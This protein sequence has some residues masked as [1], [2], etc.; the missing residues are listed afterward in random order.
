MRASCRVDMDLGL[1]EGADF[2]GRSLILGLFLLF[3]DAAEAVDG[4]YN[5]E[6]ADCRQ[7]EGEQRVDEI[8]E[9]KAGAD[10]VK[11][12]EAAAGNQEAENGRK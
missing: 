4:L 10:S 5:E 12:P 11:T 8:S 3:A 6:Q 7:Q 2:G 1:A 9:I